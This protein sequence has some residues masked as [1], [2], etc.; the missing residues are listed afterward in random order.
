M[1][2][3]NSAITFEDSPYIQQLLT[4]LR[5]KNTSSILFRKNLVSLGRYMAYELT[6]TFPVERYPLQTPVAP[7]EG[8]RISMDKIT[9]VVVLRA[10]I[11]FMEGVIKVFDKA[12][13]GIISASRGSPPD[14]SI[15]IKYVRVPNIDEDTLIIL[16]PMIATGSTLIKVFEECRKCG[17]PERKIIMGVLAAPEGV[18]RIKESYHDVEIYVAAMDRALNDKGYIVPGLGDAG[19]RAFNTEFE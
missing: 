14:F 1:I 16:D 12:K 13:V 15:E 2:E 8:L 11:P 6:R 17:N 5:D 19:D 9:I 7:A 18:G 10:A 4:I 3:R